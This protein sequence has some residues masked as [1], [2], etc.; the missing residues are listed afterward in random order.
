VEIRP[1]DGVYAQRA[2]LDAGP[3]PDDQ[4]SSPIPKAHNDAA[5][6]VPDPFDDPEPN[7]A[8]S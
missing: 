7:G 6:A 3:R 2:L 4:V 1:R 5:V 8:V